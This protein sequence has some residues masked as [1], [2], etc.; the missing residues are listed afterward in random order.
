MPIVLLHGVTRVLSPKNVAD[1]KGCHQT[2][3]EQ[4]TNSGMCESI[5]HLCKPLVNRPLQSI[6]AIQE[7]YYSKSAMYFGDTQIKTKLHGKRGN[8]LHTVRF[9]LHVLHCMTSRNNADCAVAKRV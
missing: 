6:S 1:N 2:K 3:V 4:T 7:L 8:L 5:H 9:V